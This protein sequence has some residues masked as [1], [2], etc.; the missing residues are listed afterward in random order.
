MK[1]ALI[2]MLTYKDETV[3]NALELFDE[4]KDL[5]VSHWGFKDIGLPKN[6][7]GKL[8]EDMRSAGKTTYL[9]VVSL[10]EAEGL[11]GANLAI[12]LGFDV[13]MGT[14]FFESI[15]DCLQ[16]VDVEYYPFAGHVHSHPSVLDGSIAEIVSQAKELESRGVDG[17]DL[18][19]YRYTGDATRLL[20]EVVG[21]VDLPV[22]SAGS[23]A[24]FD[25][26]L[27]VKQMGAWGFTIGTAFFE[28]RFVERGTLPE[29][30]L[31]VWRWLRGDEPGPGT[32]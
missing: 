26:I 20:G 15:S 21:A 12:E 16:G 1:P 13:L 14:V 19:T 28:K 23:I 9:E 7:M 17:L 24:S 8:V 29:N 11:A 22:V 6:E 2:V 32:C 31:A 30:V 5:P 4:M 3:G 25:R 27:E 18:L 10:S